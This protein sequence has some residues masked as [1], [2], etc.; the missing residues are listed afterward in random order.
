MPGRAHAA[1]QRALRG[2]LLAAITIALG[3]CGV[4]SPFALQSTG[5]VTAVDAVAM[6]AEVP[7]SGHRAQLHRELADALTGRS[8]TVSAD[9]RY[10]ADYS[11]SVREA[12]VQRLAAGALAEDGAHDLQ[13]TGHGWATVCC[14]G[15]D[16]HGSMYVC[17]SLYIAASTS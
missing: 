10:L 2:G 6:P 1:L 17:M 5:P 7:E 13:T 16:E 4:A 3:G 11:V 8:I 12:A 9:A 15:T 14:D